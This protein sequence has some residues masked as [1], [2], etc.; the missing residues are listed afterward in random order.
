MRSPLMQDIQTPRLR[1][2]VNTQAPVRY[3]VA[4]LVTPEGQPYRAP[5]GSIGT[6]RLSLG[7]LA[8]YQG[9]GVL[10]QDCKR[11]ATKR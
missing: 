4:P 5:E 2:V 9:T 8:Q 3:R 1:E 11:W 10:P 6:P 7:S